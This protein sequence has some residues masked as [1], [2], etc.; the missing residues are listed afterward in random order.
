[1]GT[2]SCA[3]LIH[4]KHT[5]C[6]ILISLL[7]GATGMGKSAVSRQF[8]ALGF[9]VFDADEAVHRLYAPRG[10]AGP[11]LG[12][13]FPSAIMPD[14]SVDRQELHSIILST[15]SALKSLESLVH[16]LVSDKTNNESPYPSSRYENH[17]K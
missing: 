9:R 12:P 6:L 16:P 13:Y 1:M 5:S 2:P 11:L 14:G 17:S 3:M 15:P 4:S 10:R 7:C 8:R